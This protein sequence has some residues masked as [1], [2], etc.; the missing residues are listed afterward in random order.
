MD[1][2]HVKH[3]VEASHPHPLEDVRVPDLRIEA[4]DPGVL[5]NPEHGDYSL[6]V[7]SRVVA[8]MAG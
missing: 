4:N 2:I 1:N 5:A 7:T 3:T 8:V 6:G